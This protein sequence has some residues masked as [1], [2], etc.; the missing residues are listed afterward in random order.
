MRNR[1][2]P[3][4]ILQSVFKLTGVRK[5]TVAYVGAAS[6]DNAEFRLWMAGLMQKSGAGQVTLAPLCGRQGDAEKAKVVLEA[7]DLIFVSGGDVEEGMRV[8]REKEI[9]SLLHRLHQQGK[10]FFGTSAGSIMLARQWIRWPDP[11]DEANAE[12]FDCL[13]LASVFCDTHG[14]DD[15]W[16]ELQAL[17]HLSPVGTIGHGIVSGAGLIVKPDGTVSAIG[18]EAHRFQKKASGVFQIESLCPDKTTD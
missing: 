10:L 9:I 12:L 14:E 4:P 5:P 7:S 17:L 1:K 3:D 16:E 6:G 8:L 15:G 13:G 18:G 2:G 11:D